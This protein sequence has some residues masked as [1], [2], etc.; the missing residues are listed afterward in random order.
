MRFY[1]VSLIL[2]ICGL[3]AGALSPSPAFAAAAGW[4]AGSVQQLTSGGSNYDCVNVS[5]SQNRIVYRNASNSTI[6]YAAMDNTGAT[7]I[8]TGGQYREPDI[9]SSGQVTFIDFVNGGG[10]GPGF[11][12]VHRRNSAPYSSDTATYSPSAGEGIGNYQMAT[13]GDDGAVLVEATYS[14]TQNNW[15]AF[16]LGIRRADNDTAFYNATNYYPNAAS[17]SQYIWSDGTNVIRNAATD[18]GYDGT[19]PAVNPAGDYVWRNAAD[20]YIHAVVGGTYQGAISTAA[21]YNPDIADF[22]SSTGAVWVYW[23]Q[24]DGSGE[25]IMRRLL[26]RTPT[27]ASSDITIS[28]NPITADGSTTY[29]LTVKATDGDGSGTFGGSWGILVMMSQAL[30]SW[31]NVH[32]YFGWHPTNTTGPPGFGAALE[33]GACTGGGYVGKYNGFGQQYVQLVPGSCS[34]STAGNQRTVNFVFLALT[35]WGDYQSMRVHGYA[36]DKNDATSGWVD[37]AGGTFS[38]LPAA[39]SGLSV[40]NPTLSTLDLAWTLNS[41]STETAVKVLRNAVVVATLGA[42]A[43]SWQDTGRAANTQ[44][45]YQIKAANSGGDS[46]GSNSV[47]KY[48]AIET[49]ATP[50]FGATTSSSLVLNTS[51]VSNV[52]AGSSGVWFESTNGGNTGIQAWVQ[53][54]TDTATALSP[55]T[56]Y[57]FQVK[58]RNGDGLETGWS[59]TSSRYTLPG[60]PT[61]LAKSDLTTNSLTWSWTAPAGGANGYKL[62]CNGNTVDVGAVTSATASQA[63]GFGVMNANTAYTATVLGYNSSGDGVATGG[64]T[65]YTAIETPAA[66]TFGATTS[67]SIVLN[68][69][70]ASNITVAS[71]GLWFESTTV[72]GNTGIQAWV[73]VTTDTATALSP[74]VQYDFR[75]K[76]RNGDAVET[77]WSSTTSRYTLP[78]VPTGLAHTGNATNSITWGWTAP[79]G[80]AN[81]YKLTCNGNTVDVGNVLTFVASQANGFGS[82]LANTTYTASVRAYNS[83]GD[84]VVS[85][86]VTN[87]TSIETPTGVDTDFATDTSVQ[88]RARGSLNNLT[89]GSSGLFFEYVSGG[90]GGGPSSAWTQTNTY[91]D[92]G[93]SSYTAYVYKVKARNGDGD[94]TPYTAN[95]TQYTAPAAPTPPLSWDGVAAIWTVPPGAANHHIQIYR[96]M[97]GPPG[98]LMWESD[99][100]SSLGNFPWGGAVAGNSYFFRVYAY[101]NSNGLWAGPYS[102]YS[103]GATP[104]DNTALAPI[105]VWV[106]D[107]KTG[108][109]ADPG[110]N[111]V[112][113]DINTDDITP[114]VFS[115]KYQ[116]DAW[117]SAFKARVKVSSAALADPE[118]DAADLWD[119][120]DY[121]VAPVRANTQSPDILYRGPKLN[122]NQDYHLR[123]R[124]I[125]KYATTDNE[126]TSP[127][128]ADVTF[129]IQRDVLKTALTDGPSI[130]PTTNVC[131]IR[132]TNKYH[133][134]YVY[135]LTGPTTQ[136]RFTYWRRSTGPTVAVEAVAP[137]TAPVT[138]ET[139]LSGP[140]A[141]G[142]SQYEV[143]IAPAQ[144]QGVARLGFTTTGAGSVFLDD[145]DAAVQ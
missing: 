38:T 14:H 41:G 2:F 69:S 120:G 112:R 103:A 36:N 48:T 110:S 78:D 84:G 96:D 63:N 22:D 94:E 65:N 113:G 75:V 19:H 10:A 67:S 51:G 102:V 52:A 49:P 126:V 44:Y 43:S 39:P 8:I 17:L 83:S 62:T 140:D 26:T 6:Y 115:A 134:R 117:D 111:V 131:E 77:G 91:L 53:V 55:N 129:R 21:G 143:V 101:V 28:A 71:S 109:Q 130:H 50:T 90:A 100:N 56:S 68:T 92:S 25:Q 1:R 86:G 108:A 116:D 95:Y 30:G 34:T 29:T 64:V 80:G 97:P 74:N 125:E 119:S 3:L 82:F 141:N 54:T 118:N 124:F 128:S 27:L 99:S 106:S 122:N 73:Q 142:W 121:A 138:T 132:E 72:G 81:G 114:V 31:T 24:S 7:A 18:T 104:V 15:P 61:G 59:S 70:G 60:I 16:S 58:A 45:T 35:N 123:F 85:G 42:D 135:D 9:N 144:S 79:G 20:G 66:P 145:I 93:L 57:T 46:A 32:G 133:F 37:W 12:Y 88:L 4:T 23:I 5:L 139:L 98:Q 136:V 89:L 107:A 87:Y 33:T 127:W 105:D 13:I 137:G 47:A 11:S 40:T 76:G